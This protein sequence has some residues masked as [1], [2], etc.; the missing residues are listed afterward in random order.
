LLHIIITAPADHH[1]HRFVV[2]IEL[3]T[4]PLEI[5]QTP[6]ESQACILQLFVDQ[7]VEAQA[8]PPLAAEVVIL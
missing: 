3:N 8:T 6:L 5:P 7:L 1:A 2:G 4:P